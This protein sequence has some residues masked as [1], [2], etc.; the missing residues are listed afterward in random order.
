MSGSGRPD[1]VR[2]GSVGKPHGVRGGFYV[3]GAID[4][5]AMVPGAELLVGGRVFC[6]TSRAGADARPILTL[7][8]ISDRDAAASLRGAEITAE[9]GVL[10]PLSEGEWFASDLEGMEV[11]SRAG[12][13]LGVVRR[14]VNMPSVD[15][16]EVAVAGGGDDVLVPMIGDAIV[17]ID[18][19]ARV[20]TVNTEFLDLG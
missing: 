15:V 16:L 7:E 9:R 19:D 18:A 14:L 8:G 10:T 13:A 1:L 11:R 3:D 17:S 20:V 12:D 2:I 5:D 6:V 4:P